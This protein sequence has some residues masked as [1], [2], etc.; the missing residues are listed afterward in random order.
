[1]EEMLRDLDYVPPPRMGRKVIETGKDYAHRRLNEIT[2]SLD[3]LERRPY[4]MK[5]IFKWNHPKDRNNGG[6]LKKLNTREVYTEAYEE[7]DSD[8]K[9]DAFV[10][11]IKSVKIKNMGVEW[12]P[13]TN[14]THKKKY[15]HVHFLLAVEHDTWL[16]V[17]G[18]GLQNYYL[19]A[20]NDDLYIGGKVKNVY[21]N[22]KFV[23]DN[24]YKLAEY[25]H[26]DQNKPGPFVAAEDEL[27][28]Q[29]SQSLYL[30]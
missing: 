6:A 28:Q 12:G 4:L 29:F 15:L 5:Q 27:S 24:F 16:L 8:D 14:P 30:R 23:P 21:V 20:F 11:H 7:G 13:G 25:I 1:M 10:G 26:K 2:Q 22:I 9:K 19:T 3:W 17:D 18:K